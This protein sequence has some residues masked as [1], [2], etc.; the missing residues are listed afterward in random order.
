MNGSKILVVD[1]EP[2]LELLITQRFRRQIR[3]GEFAFRFAR[4]GA[5]ALEM[6]MADPEIEIILSDINMPVMDGLTLLSELAK[7]PS[8]RRAVIVS[9]YGDMT[10]IRTAMNRGAFDFITKPIDMT[11][12]EVTI[13]K[14]VE[15]IVRT[16][17]IRRQRD[18]AQRMRA[19][20]ARYFSPNLVDIL[21]RQDEPFGPVRRQNVAVLF[22]DIVGFTGLAE[23]MD[24][25]QVMETLREYHR[26]MSNQIFACDGTLEKF[27]G[28]AM[29]AT[30]G[31]PQA[32]EHDAGNA[33]RCAELMLA[34]LA[35]WNTERLAAGLSCIDIGIGVN[36][37][38][39][40]LGNL[41]GEHGMSFTVIGD[42]VN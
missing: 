3:A 16:G 31:V 6:L 29:L 2:D 37:G 22:A 14:T 1:D 35:E 20:L 36:Y 5:Q 38:P 15:E 27:I 34:M 40:V 9:A 32:S 39:V 18:E 24:P 28:D 12:L 17:E 11:D 10:N 7:R 19:N 21:A 13:R 4:D 23:T 26:R 41:G 25:E 42:T 30:F 8:T 33:L